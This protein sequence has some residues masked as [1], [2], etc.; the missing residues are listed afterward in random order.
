MHKEVDTEN[1]GNMPVT[2]KQGF[3][4]QQRHAQYYIRL[5][6]YNQKRS[7]NNKDRDRTEKSEPVF[8]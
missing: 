8:T 1:D 2:I 4:T 6:R 7:W 5:V 3:L